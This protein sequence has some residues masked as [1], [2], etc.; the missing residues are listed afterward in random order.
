MC[1][2]EPFFTQGKLIIPLRLQER[3]VVETQQILII[4]AAVMQE[5]SG[6]ILQIRRL[7]SVMIIT[8]RQEKSAEEDISGA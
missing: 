1:I 6:L 2:Q 7:K 3:I 8:V 5:N 4:M